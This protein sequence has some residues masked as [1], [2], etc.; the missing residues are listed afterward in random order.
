M[1]FDSGR[2]QYRVVHIGHLP[3]SLPKIIRFLDS[4][5]GTLG[6]AARKSAS[7]AS[8]AIAPANCSLSP[9]S[10][11]KPCSLCVIKLG[12]PA[13]RVE[14]T[15]VSSAMA[16]STTLGNPSRILLSTKTS[17]ACSMIRGSASCPRRN[18]VPSSP[19]RAI[20]C[21]KALRQ[22]PSPPIHSVIATPRDRNSA[23]QSI[24]TSKPFSADKR[25]K[26]ATTN[27]LPSIPSS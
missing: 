7:L 16:S 15:G 3:H 11:N 25:P 10:T 13:T 20:C 12:T 2:A 6:K 8:R 17:A 27:P 9:I 5:P 26:A 19:S 21:S 22:P 24:N 23:I 14:M 1:C 4:L 18:T